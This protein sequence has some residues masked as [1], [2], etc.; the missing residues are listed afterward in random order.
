MMIF[1]RFISFIIWIIM[2]LE[3]H[4]WKC[5]LV[6]LPKCCLFNLIILVFLSIRRLFGFICIVL[7]LF[8]GRIISQSLWLSLFIGLLLFMLYMCLIS[9]I[10]LSRK[11]IFFSFYTFWIIWKAQAFPSPFKNPTN[12]FY[13]FILGL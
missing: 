11:V 6:Y 3:H 8:T 13:L 4:R 7:D 9:F 2:G 1:N 10:N 12:P 5:H